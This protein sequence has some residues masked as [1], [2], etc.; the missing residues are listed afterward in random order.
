LNEGK[1]VLPPHAVKQ[2]VVREYAKRHGLRL[3]V[4]TETYL[5][6]MVY[7]VRRI[8]DRDLLD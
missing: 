4:E 6:G 3:L 2:R 7:A 8:F 1:P 5:G